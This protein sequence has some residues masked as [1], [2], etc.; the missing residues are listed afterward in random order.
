MGKLAHRMPMLATAFPGASHRRN[1]ALDKFASLWCPAPHMILTACVRT[2]SQASSGRR[3]CRKTCRKSCARRKS[4]LLDCVGPF[5]SHGCLRTGACCHGKIFSSKHHVGALLV[6]PSV[7]FGRV[8]VPSQLLIR[9]FLVFLRDEL[10]L[11]RLLVFIWWKDVSCL[12][13]CKG[14]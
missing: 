3:T 8:S 14:K 1:V 10:T 2:R 4:L 5:F 7:F 9:I 11:S 13:D 6:R 12:C